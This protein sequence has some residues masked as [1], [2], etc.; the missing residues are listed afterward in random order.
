[1]ARDSKKDT[2]DNEE[3]EKKEYQKPALTKYRQIKRIIGTP[4]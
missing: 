2:K 4:L 3:R 1:M